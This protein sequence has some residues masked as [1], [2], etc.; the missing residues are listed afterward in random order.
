MTNQSS[1][2]DT[3]KIAMLAVAVLAL[4]AASFL[5]YRNFA[6]PAPAPPLPQAPEDLKTSEPAPLPP[7]VSRPKPG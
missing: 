1:G 6:E 4:A 5:L 2:T 7:N 3:K